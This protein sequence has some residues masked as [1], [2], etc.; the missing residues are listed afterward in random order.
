M[1]RVLHSESEQRRA[2]YYPEAAVAVGRQVALIFGEDSSQ[3]TQS[4]DGVSLNNRAVSVE[5]KQHPSVSLVGADPSGFELL[6]LPRDIVHRERCTHFVAP[7]M[8]S[9]S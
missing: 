1:R 8:T 5:Y 9:V 3:A 6:R 7:L 4:Q 2:E